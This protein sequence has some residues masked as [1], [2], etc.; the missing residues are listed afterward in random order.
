M[1]TR[2]QRQRRL[3]AFA[4]ARVQVLIAPPYKPENCVGKKGEERLKERVQK[5]LAGVQAKL[6]AVEIR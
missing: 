5:V 1:R 6:A 4:S 2:P 3:L